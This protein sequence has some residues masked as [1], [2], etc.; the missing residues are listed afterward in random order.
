MRKRRS[1]QREATLRRSYE[2]IR[3]LAGRLINAQEAARA[4]I[5][6]DLHDDVCQQLVFVS[7]AVSTLKN[8]SGRI[9]DAETQQA[10]SD[11]EGTTQGVLEGIRLLSHDLHPDSLRL[12]G[13]GPA[14]KV[15]CGEV[16]KRYDVE[17]S[18][19]T[20]G[21]IRPLHQDVAVCLF[22]IAQESLRNGVVHS[23]ARRFGVTLVR[24][25]DHVELTVTDDGHGFDLEVVRRE[26]SGLGLVSMEERA[27][28]VGGDVQITTGFEKGTTIRVRCPS[29]LPQSGQIAS[30][31]RSDS[32]EVVGHV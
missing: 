16:A 13:L 28:V 19:T 32:P 5:A 8:S 30:V 29:E 11:L 26:G 21:D 1:A 3:Q 9:Q 15:H 22:R 2:R 7:I 20:E 6:R 23:G 31:S 27:H 12:L 14:L 17:V 25:D 4:D 24:S 10:F 18:F